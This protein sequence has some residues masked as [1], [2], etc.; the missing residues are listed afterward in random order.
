LPSFVVTDAPGVV[1]V[2]GA[3]FHLG[4][5]HI[6]LG[7]DHLLYVLAMLLVVRGWKRIVATMTAFTATHSLTLSGAALGWVHVPQPPVEA[8]IALSILFVASE[9][10]RSREG[11]PGLTARWPWIVSF[12]FGLLHGF[13]F[14]GALS[15]IGLPAHAIPVALLCFNVGVEAGQLLFIV[16]VFAVFGAARWLSRRLRF[17]QPSW[18]WRVPSYAIGGMAAFWLIQRSAS[19]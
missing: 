5:E 1:Q 13:G 15:E 2:A 8:C 7:I 4:V 16:G 12:T 3:Y 11:R 9:I 19:F 6:L 18:A 10:V 17:R 14:A